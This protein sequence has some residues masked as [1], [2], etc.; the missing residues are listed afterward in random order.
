M[1]FLKSKSKVIFHIDLNQFYC[2]VAILKNPSLKGKAFA[3]GRENS[4]KGVI[5]TASYEARA[6]GVN[7]GMSLVDA[8]RKYP[9]LIVVNHTFDLYHDYSTRFF[10]LLKEYVK[11]IERT[12]IDE[13]YLDVTEITLEKG[14]HP[15]SLAKEIQKRSLDEI[16]LPCSVGIAPTLYL[17]K[18][19]SDMKKPLGI[20][21]LR[22]RDIKD[23]LY[24][25][26]VKDIFGI[27]KKTWPRLMKAGINTIGDFMNP[28][29]KDIVTKIIGE[30]MYTQECAC[31]SGNSTNI[32]DPNRYSDPESISRTQTFDYPLDNFDDTY[33]EIVN[34]AKEAYLEM[35]EEKKKTKTIG[36]ILRDKTFK[37]IT[38]GKTLPEA[39]TDFDTISFTLEDLLLENYNDDLAYRLVG[40]SLSNLVDIN[41]HLP[42]EIN[43]FNYEEYYGKEEKIKDIIRKYGKEKID[44]V[45]NKKVD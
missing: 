1:I 10:N 12:S 23:K 5:S 28:L 24:P 15:V 40:A 4:T 21:I 44:F 39:T 2:T 19:A 25:L 6:K 27:G 30:K 29:N 22:K 16:G 36:I 33:R 14:I 41:Y 42:E 32:V 43:L 11:D 17:A 20:T 13:G 37:T 18:M 9:E 31:L 26:P 34:L 8:F 38:R 3:V 35:L 45:K 7:S